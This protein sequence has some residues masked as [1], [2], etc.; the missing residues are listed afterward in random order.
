MNAG[1]TEVKIQ[2]EKSITIPNDILSKYLNELQINEF[3][4]GDIGIFSV[5]VYAEKPGRKTDKKRKQLT[6]LSE[7]PC[8][9]PDGNC[10]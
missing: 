5:T 8:C 9:S 7:E 4:S 3:E 10:C 1:F 2:K 6:N